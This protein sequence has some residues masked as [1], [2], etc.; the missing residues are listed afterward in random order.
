MKKFLKLTFFLIVS[1]SYSQIGIT[2]VKE[3]KKEEIV[4]DSLYNF[5]GKN[6]EVLIG[7]ELFLKPK[8]E[9]LIKYGYDNFLKDYK[10]SFVD[11]KNIYLKQKDGY[12]TEYDSIESK[13]FKVLDVIRDNYNFFKLLNT[14]NKDT[15]YYR[16]SSLS[17]SSFEFI[18]KGY[19]EKL[20]S[21]IKNQRFILKDG[22]KA[23][24]DDL[25]INEMTKEPMFWKVESVTLEDKYYSIVFNMINDNGEQKTFYKTS[26]FRS[27]FTE[28]EF[29]AIKE[30]Y[31]TYYNK[32][33]QGKIAIG[34][35]KEAVILSWGKPN[36]I[37]NSS[38][39][40]QWVYESQYLY[41]KD[42]K[43]T[44]FN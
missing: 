41:F 20:S 12:N 30:K 16:I 13:Y 26:V 8:S 24:N 11:K 42:G 37:N 39:N 44:S 28:K 1:T 40:E 9:T 31:P 23:L 43:L 3:E 36:K 7:Q 18:V 35:P 29:N 14:H 34:M 19:F 17:E 33:L 25:P 32:I 21:T 4:Y 38:Y 10:R 22:I 6:L 15:L 5:P 27:G 2:K